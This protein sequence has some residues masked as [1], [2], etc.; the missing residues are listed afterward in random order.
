MYA[1]TKQEG[2][3]TAGVEAALRGIRGAGLGELEE[4][5]RAVEARRRELVLA[6]EGETLPPTPPSVV[7]ARPYGDGWLQL[8]MRTYE[9][10]SGG[11]SGRG[12]D[13][14]FR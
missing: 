1:H 5:T 7:G 8:E 2:A 12:P 10:K 4:L 11:V 13:W 14:Y 6:G 9:R 3:G